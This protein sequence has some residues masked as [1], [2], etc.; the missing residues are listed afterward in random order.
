MATLKRIIALRKQSGDEYY[1]FVE[2]DARRTISVIRSLPFVIGYV[3]LVV[4]IFAPSLLSAR[5][6]DLLYGGKAYFDFLNF[7]LVMS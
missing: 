6:I 4:I 5:W 7:R 2:R 3:T 1:A